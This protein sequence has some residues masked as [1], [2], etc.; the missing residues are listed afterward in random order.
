[1]INLQFKL[2]RPSIPKLLFLVCHR[3]VELNFNFVINTNRLME[4]L[5]DSTLNELSI[6]LFTV[7]F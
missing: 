2:K 1:M 4:K 6:N 7:L 5:R 3:F